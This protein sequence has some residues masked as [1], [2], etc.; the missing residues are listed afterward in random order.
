MT[1]EEGLRYIKATGNAYRDFVLRYTDRI[2]AMPKERARQFVLDK[3][4]EIR[5]KAAKQSIRKTL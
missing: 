4:D 1:D 2:L 3:A 5:D